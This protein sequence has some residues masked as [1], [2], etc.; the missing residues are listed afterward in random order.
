[1]GKQLDARYVIE[2]SIRKAG[3]RV[4][5]T[6]QLINAETGHHVWAERYDRDLE[7]VFEL[8]DLLTQQIVATVTPELERTEHSLAVSRQP[9]SMEAWDYNLRGWAHYWELR[10]GAN[11]AAR[12]MF[13]KAMELDPS[14]SSA[15]TGFVCTCIREMPFKFGSDREAL[16]SKAI[17][18]GQRAIELDPSDSKA[19]QFLG[20]ALGWA[21]Q[22]EQGIAEEEKAISLNPSNDGAYASKG[23]QLTLAGRPE[24]GIPYLEKGLRLSPHNWAGPLFQSFLARA[25]LTAQRYSEAA[26]WARRAVRA[27]SDLPEAQLLLAASL[28]HLDELDKARAAMTEYERLRPGIANGNDSWMPFKY[29]KDLDNFLTGLRKAGWEG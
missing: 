13:S 8:Q 1:V 18:M 29:E 9:K 27:R 17:E 26:D 22:Q 2:G 12:E 20:I 28:G 24:E 10:P 23:H 6:A 19:H 11:V 25:H 16:C 14:Y 15:Y 7:D 5:V 3:N 4:R 21:G